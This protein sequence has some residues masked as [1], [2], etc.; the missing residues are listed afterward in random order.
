M[1]L[2]G[3]NGNYR[4]QLLFTIMLDPITSNQINWRVFQGWVS[5][6]ISSLKSSLGWSCDLVL[7]NQ[8]TAFSDFELNLVVKPGTG[9]TNLQAFHLFNDQAVK[10]LVIALDSTSW[11]RN[12]IEMYKMKFIPKM[13]AYL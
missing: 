3:Q 11:I 5:P 1:S 10:N 12:E 6:K 8:K 4:H 7:A 13:I 9:I 2:R